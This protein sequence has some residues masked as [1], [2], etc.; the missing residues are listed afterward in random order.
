MS[1]H[2]IF[3]TFT[4]D[5]EVKQIRIDNG[6][7][8]RRINVD[9]QPISICVSPDEQFL[10]V[11]YNPL[12][13]VIQNSHIRKYRVEDGLMLPMNGC[14][15]NRIC[16]SHDGEFLFISRE[17]SNEIQVVKA[18]D[19]T[20]VR[21]IQLPRKIQML[22][23]YMCLSP[24]G[25]FLFVI[26]NSVREIHLKHLNSGDYRTIQITVP[27]SCMYS[28]GKFLFTSSSESNRVQVLNIDDGSVARTVKCGNLNIGIDNFCMYNQEIFTTRHNYNV[29]RVFQLCE[30]CE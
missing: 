3:V 7:I 24:D 4:N 17:L 14:R 27:T 28:D 26:Y 25:E 16:I 11:A 21:T 22:D 9:S 6:Q 29:I 23:G 20:N 12:N 30:L 8:I 5:S 1:S 19:G 2:Y 18:L 13:L 10:Y 15:G